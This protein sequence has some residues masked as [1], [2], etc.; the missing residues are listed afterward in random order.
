MLD[1]DLKAESGKHY[2]GQELS[3]KKES[4]LDKIKSKLPLEPDY[5]IESRNGF[6]VYYLINPSERKIGSEEWSSIEIGIFDY[7]KANISNNVDH[8][9]KKSNQIMRLPYSFHK[10]ADDTD[11]GYPVKIIY[12]RKR[13]DKELYFKNDLYESAMFAY[14]TTK[15]KKAFK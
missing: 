7:V 1:F 14:P 10:K 2:K 13:E 15:I 12:E 3:D 8:A 9:V 5:I 6:H 11:D 4:L